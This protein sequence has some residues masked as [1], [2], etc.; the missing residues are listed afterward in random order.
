MVRTPARATSAEGRGG[1]WSLRFIG[2]ADEGRIGRLYQD[3]RGT[4]FFEYDAAWRAGRRDFRR[5]SAE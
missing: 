1:R 3:A 2:S 4:V 5:L